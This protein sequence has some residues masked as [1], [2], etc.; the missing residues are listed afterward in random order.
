MATRIS[1][2]A[3]RT[4]KRAVAAAGGVEV[5]HLKNHIAWLQGQ[6]EDVDANVASLTHDYCDLGERS[7]WR[8]PSLPQ[9]DETIRF[10]TNRLTALRSQLRDAR[11]RLLSLQAQASASAKSSAAATYDRSAGQRGAQARVREAW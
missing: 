8:D 3:K 11:A 4:A 2:L 9:R 10:W 5:V 6:V 7:A 1:T